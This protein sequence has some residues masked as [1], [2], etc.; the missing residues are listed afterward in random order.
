M[1]DATPERRGDP[2]GLSRKQ[3][4]RSQ[5]QD[6]PPPLTPLEASRRKERERKERVVKN[7][8]PTDTDLRRRE[9]RGSGSMPHGTKGSRKGERLEDHPPPRRTP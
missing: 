6:E 1:A 3:P 5:I 2:R 9:A 7:E 8:A 4:G